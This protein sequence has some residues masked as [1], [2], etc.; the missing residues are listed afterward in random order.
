M[1]EEGSLGGVACVLH[2][3]DAS[4]ERAVCGGDGHRAPEKADWGTPVWSGGKYPEWKAGHPVVCV[5]WEDAQAYCKWA[6]LRLPGEL[7]WEKAA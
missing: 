4:D 3:V 1:R 6:G 5:S 7:E 2:G